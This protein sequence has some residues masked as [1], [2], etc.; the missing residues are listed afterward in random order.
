MALITR[1]SRLFKADFNAVLDRMEE[2]EILLKLAIREMEDELGLDEQQVK[3]IA[4]E[5]DQLTTRQNELQQQLQEASAELDL[6]FDAENEALA[7]SLLKRRLEAERLQKYLARKHS[8][9]KGA[10]D[11]L[12]RRVDENR[13]RLESMRQK[14]EL[15]AD[16]DSEKTLSSAWSEP[17][18]LRQFTVSEEDIELAF[19]R[20]RQ[21]RAQP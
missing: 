9:L 21:R 14:A 2:P 1:L 17:D 3:L 19:L 15:L 16:A 18:F 20:E 8:E 12:N 10:G 6:C 7:K 5:M 13:A 4:L 11:E